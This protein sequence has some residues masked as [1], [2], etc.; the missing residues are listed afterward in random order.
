MKTE[1]SA[2]VVARIPRVNLIPGAERERLARESLVRRWL[3]AILVTIAAVA[4]ACA[5]AT[6]LA[7]DAGQR[8]A[9]ERARV[10]QLTA[11]LEGLGEVSGAVHLR[12]ELESLRAQ[13]LEAGFP[14]LL[15]VGDAGDV[16]VTVGQ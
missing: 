6:L 11:E 15:D 2:L 3:L 12:A 7:W 16:V 1:A 14:Y 13:I 9:D 4:F 8:V 5:G 10:A